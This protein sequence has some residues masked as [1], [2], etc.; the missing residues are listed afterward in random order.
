MKVNQIAD[1]SIGLSVTPA[2]TAGFSVPLL[3]VD[4][5]DVPI[6]RRYIITSRSSFATDL[7]ADSDAEEWATILW[8]QNYNPSQ[9]YIGRWISTASNP[10]FVCGDFETDPTVWAAI[11]DGDLTVTTTAGA[12]ILAALDFTAP[13]TTMAAVALVFDTAL[14]AGGVSGARCSL[15]AL[16][17][18]VFTDPAV[19]GAGADTVLLTQ[20]G[21]GTDMTLPAWLDVAG[22][23]QVG[24]VDAEGL[25]D[26]LAAIMALDDTA[27]VIHQRGGSIAQQVDLATA[28][29]TYRKVCELTNND[30]DAKDSTK[31]TDVGYLLE[32]LANK[33]THITYTEHTTQSPDAALNGEIY[34]RGEEGAHSLALNALT[35]VFE[36]GLDSDGT[37]V[38]PLTD[39]ERSALEAKG[40]DYL[41][42]PSSSVHCVTGLTTGAVEM[43]HRVGFYW[44]EARTSEDIYAYLL[45]NNVTTFS[46]P[47]IAAIG[48]ILNRYLE[49]LVQR[50]TIEAGYTIN[51]PS[52][53]SFSAAVKATH[54]LTLSDVA[55]LVGEIAVNSVV[56]TL[57]ATV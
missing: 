52:A 36:S 6:D 34:A 1:V 47:D 2:A 41:V 11:S 54:V 43:R 19:T 38:I 12:D 15:D 20:S 7:T 28:V 21:A 48:G 22:G 53:A 31:S 3:L 16:D 26:A 10:Y 35:S 39:G 18:I 40:Y 46:D 9:A 42:K 45:A 17:R 50:K 29:I 13:V 25:D 33:N 32:A 56:M 27:F 8:G 4:T 44:A 23:F 24:G 51:L 49:I 5:T 37:T 30:S 55:Q 57:S 14:V